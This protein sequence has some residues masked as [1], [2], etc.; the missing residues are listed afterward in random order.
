MTIRKALRTQ[1]NLMRFLLQ[2]EGL[3]IVEYAIAAGLGVA[4][5]VVSFGVLGA[6]VN[7]IIATITAAL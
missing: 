2:D 5:V 4:T 6:A 1:E 3:T 7:A